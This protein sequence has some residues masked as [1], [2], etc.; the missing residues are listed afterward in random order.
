MAFLSDPTTQFITSIALTV[1][2]FVIGIAVSLV[3]YRKQSRKEIA[4][5]IVSNTSVISINA[6]LKGRAQIIYNG[7]PVSDARLVILRIWNAGN[8]AIASNEYDVPIT[9]SF[10]K[11]AEILDFEVLEASPHN[12]QVSFKQDGQDLVLEPVLLNGQDSI[13]LKILLTQFNSNISVN[14]RIVGV[15]QIIRAESTYIASY[16]RTVFNL[17]PTFRML[18]TFIVAA[19]FIA[20][21]E[22]PH[23]FDIHEFV[24]TLISIIIAAFVTSVLFWNIR[25]FVPQNVRLLFVLIIFANFFTFSVLYLL[26]QLL[27]EHPIPY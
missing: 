13:K 19:L 22:S 15:K 1:V 2:L 12:L 26:I 6:E 8:L 16:L 4:Y 11:D 24:I 25:R 21:F 3:I 17:R 14:A 9:L 5:E 27:L 18:I 10:G 7:K 23:P 20:V